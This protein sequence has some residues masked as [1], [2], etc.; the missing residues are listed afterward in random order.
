MSNRQSTSAARK[1]KE[2]SSDPAEAVSRLSEVTHRM[3]TLLV[4]RADELV[5]GTE[6]SPGEA[7]S[8]CPRRLR[9][10]T[11]GD[12]QGLLPWRQGVAL[13]APIAVAALNDGHLRRVG[14]H[15]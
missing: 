13:P 10:P 7:D 2:R 3:H 5:G 4:A 12:G 6:N 8:G 14:R 9:A 15:R 11:V 1:T